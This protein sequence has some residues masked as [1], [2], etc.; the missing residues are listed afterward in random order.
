MTTNRAAPTPSESYTRNLDKLAA[1]LRA[2]SLTVK[3]I[4]KQLKCCK[5][6]VYARIAALQARGDRVFS[7]LTEASGTGPRPQAY[8]IAE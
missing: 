4:S 1:L 6:T 3:E 8:G 5:P 7:L 2:K